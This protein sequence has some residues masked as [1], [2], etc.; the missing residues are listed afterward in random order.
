M[1]R[2]ACTVLA[3]L[4]IASCSTDPNS[5]AARESNAV[6]AC[7]MVV[8][9]TLVAQNSYKPEFPWHFTDMDDGTGFVRRTFDATNGFGGTITSKYECTF[10]YVASTV[11]ML[12]VSKP[13]GGWKQII[14]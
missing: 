4:T 14:G 7:D 11:I 10:R 2:V 1:P 5:P 3:A 9:Q 6:T 13:S 8:T 12:R